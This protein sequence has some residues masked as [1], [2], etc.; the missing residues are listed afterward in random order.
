MTSTGLKQHGAGH[1]MLAFHITNI[2]GSDFD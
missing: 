1:C 2:E